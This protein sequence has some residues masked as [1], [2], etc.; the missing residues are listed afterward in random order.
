M[1]IIQDSSSTSMSYS[2]PG[3]SR[4]LDFIF[5]NEF[6]RVYLKIS[7]TSGI[8]RNGWKFD[9]TCLVAH[10]VA[11]GD[12][13]HF[14]FQSNI[15][16][17]VIMYEIFRIIKHRQFVKTDRIRNQRHLTSPGPVEHPGLNT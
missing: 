17:V 13:R 12:P 15:L 4:L 10:Y 5:S 6:C 2:S 1:S 7:E 9:K 14:S 8:I 11:G 16:S 3:L